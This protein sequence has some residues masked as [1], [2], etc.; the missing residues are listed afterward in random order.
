MCGSDSG[1]T[2]IPE[3]APRRLVRAREAEFTREKVRTMTTTTSIH[4]TGLEGGQVAVTSEQLD[5]LS[6]GIDGSLLRPGDEGWDAAVVIWNGMVAATPAL[7][8]QPMSVRD[9]VAAVPLQ[10]GARI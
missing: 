3:I 2:V 1:R 7:V 4:L 5:E 8:I 9:V 10:A 6:S